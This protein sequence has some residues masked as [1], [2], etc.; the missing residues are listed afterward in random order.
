MALNHFSDELSLLSFKKDLTGYSF[1]I[2]RQD[3]M[4][5]LSVA[6]M[7][8]PQAMAYAMLAGL[9][10]TC[11]LFAAI[12][13]SI[14]AAIFGSSRH[15]VV[16]PSNAIA[17]L[18]QSGTSEILFTHYRGLSGAELDIMSVQVLTQLCL[19]IGIFQV[20][21]AGCKLGRLTQFISHSVVVGYISGAAIAVVINQLFTFLGVPTFEGDHS[22]Y[23]KAAYLV[24]HALESHWPTALVGISSLLL[25][26]FFKRM[27][28][29][30]PAPV[31]T[32]ALAGVVVSILNLTV[33]NSIEIEGIIEQRWQKVLLVGDSGN[34]YQVWPIFAFPF[35]DTSIMNQML[36]FAFAVALLSVMETSSV[37]KTIAASSG[38]RLS[39]N[40]EIFGVGLGNLLS[41]FISAMPV[42]G[43]PSRSGLNF[44]NGGQTRMAAILNAVFVAFI[45]YSFSFLIMHIPLAAL[46]ALLLVT[47]A[48]II[49]P[50]HFFLCIKAT[51]SDAFV[52]W[53]TLLSCVFFS[54][55]I[56]FYIGIIL[57]I[58]LYLKKAA[59]PQLVEYDIDDSGELMNL[60]LNKLHEH[61]TIRVIKVEGELFFGAADLFQTTLKTI[62][63]D[64]TSTRVIILQLKN[65][66]DIDA[67]VCLALQQLCDYLRGSGRHLVA[68]G[69]TQ[70][71]WDVLSDSG[72]IEQ[73]GKC[74]LFIF[75]ERHPHLYM[76]K[77]LHRARE[78]AKEPGPVTKESVRVTEEDGVA[79]AI[80]EVIVPVN[81]NAKSVI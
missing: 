9:P 3:A 30:I 29:R 42:G 38:Q 11:G 73:I 50:R 60:D 62:A 41:S 39:T 65:A 71:I 61:K 67:T 48:N 7:T 80:K 43:S 75:D 40:Q 15:L 53:T 10:L 26:I 45:L 47:A 64:D 27:D 56:A 16:G 13:S 31:I 49:N 35:F 51:S 74:N 57:S 59:I 66:R 33:F 34:V 58:T 23:E 55:D 21:A 63:E 36:P 18:V 81:V 28:K 76:L 68:C 79:E 19:L 17:I 32:L 8:V 37:S 5:A 20:L 12:Y 25:L 14:I 4:A 22:L 77:A 6:L 69:L 1:D 70:Q 78:L 54:L 44:A 2:F 72:M 52:L 46:S 24:T